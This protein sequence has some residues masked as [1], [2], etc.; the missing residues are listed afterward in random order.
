[1]KPTVTC[2]KCKQKGHYS[3][4]CKNK[5]QKFLNIAQ[6][7][8]RKNTSTNDRQFMRPSI[9]HKVNMCRIAVGQKLLSFNGKAG[10]CDIN[11][12]IDTAASSSIISEKWVKENMIETICCEG[13]IEVADGNTIQFNKRTKPLTIKIF[14]HSCTMSL[15]VT[16]LPTQIEALLGLDWFAI[17]KATID[18]ANKSLQ[19]P[20]FQ[21]PQDITTDSEYLLSSIEINNTKLIDQ[22]EQFDEDHIWDF[23][24]H[25]LDLT[26]IAHLKQEDKDKALTLLKYNEDVFVNSYGTIGCC[27]IQPFTITT[28]TE[29]PII[30][31]PYR[32]SHKERELINDEIQKMLNAGIIK[33]STSR[34]AASVVLIP[35]PDQTV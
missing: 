32:K 31:P 18:P 7:I 12:I 22:E 30:I 21:V 11:F 26:T 23:S 4:E 9:R 19:F 27:T 1:M 10:Q 5:E 24:E 25:K 20:I 14:S 3:T 29:N 8:S 17:S 2:F 15:I 13:N 33:K 6:E 28:T 35:K 16:K 34:W